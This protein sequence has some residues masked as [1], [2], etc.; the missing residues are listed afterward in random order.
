[1]LAPGKLF[2]R[3]KNALN[4]TRDVRY[5][6]VQSALEADT[7]FNTDNLNYRLLSLSPSDH[8]DVRMAVEGTLILGAIGSGKSSGS[9]AAYAR[10]FLSAGYGGLICC[11]RQD[12][13]RAW[14][15]YA[16]KTGRSDSL[17]IVS[18]QGRYRCNPVDYLLKR[19]GTT[20][21]RIEQ[22][23]NF[24]S[25]IAEVAERGDKGGGGKHDRFFE[26]TNKR[27]IRAVTEVCFRARGATG[28]AILDEVMMSS[29]RTHEEVHDPAWQ[30]RSLCYRMITEGDA[31]PMTTQERVD[32]DRAAAFLLRDIPDMPPETRGSV[33]ATWGTMVDPLLRGQMAELFGTETNFIPELS[34]NG[35]VIVLDLSTEVFGHYGA[36]LMAAFG[37]I[38]KLA[39]SQRD[40]DLY[41]RPVFW[42]CDE[43]A[44]VALRSDAKWLSVSAR[45]KRC[46]AVLIGQTTTGIQAA[47][48]GDSAK[49]AADNL[50]A[51]L[52]TKI[53]HAN[54]GATNRWASGLFA[55]DWQVR[56][57]FSASNG[58]HQNASGGGSDML[59]ST[60]L[61]SE[62]TRL[63]KGGPES[64]FCTE[65]IVFCGGKVWNATGTTALRT[66]FRQHID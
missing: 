3:L 9:A 33:F 11:C 26:Q 27:A 44:E 42:F 14:E 25:S 15:R 13:R 52:G 56:T 28:M 31:K 2:T 24:L 59:E 58:E 20:A 65:A 55:R 43:Y 1:M 48:G 61:E 16:A 23:V 35:A 64:N 54:S 21:S 51:A 8:V 7:E 50:F 32:F 37:Y 40:L 46:C 12:E 17:I 22:V 63:K 6:D 36:V 45:H 60:V 4:P 57:N 30:Q 34:F 47:L 38:W 18:P 66:I 41:P 62:F 49:D 10:A 19:P 39:V 53:F 5:P 29:P